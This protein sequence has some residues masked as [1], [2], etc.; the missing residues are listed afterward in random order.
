MS[1]DALLRAFLADTLDLWRVEGTVTAGTPP[2]VAEIHVG[3][4]TLVS[5]ERIAQGTMP[6]R[7]LVRARGASAA[8]EERPRPC[9]SLVGVLGAMRGALGIDRGTALRIAPAPADE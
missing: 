6:F 1:S 4:G 2:S 7:W 3:D 8:R 5:L 9:G